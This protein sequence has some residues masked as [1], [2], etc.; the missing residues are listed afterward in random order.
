MPARKSANKGGMPT[1]HPG[2]VA[3]MFDLR[4][5]AANPMHYDLMASAVKGIATKAVSTAFKPKHG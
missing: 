5:H 2:Q 3:A 4:K 1:T